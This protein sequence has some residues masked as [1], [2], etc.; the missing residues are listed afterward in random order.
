M[1]SHSWQS[2]L[3]RPFVAVDI[4]SYHLASMPLPVTAAMHAEDTANNSET[5]IR[6]M[7]LH[8]REYFLDDSFT[9][10]TH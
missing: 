10:K 6:S 5:I 2:R 1:P 7:A 3:H 8:R 4:T 9:T